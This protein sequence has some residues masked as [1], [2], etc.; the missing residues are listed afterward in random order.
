MSQESELPREFTA[1][2]SEI[3]P[4]RAGAILSSFEIAKRPCVWLNSM[5]GDPEDTRGEIAALGVELERL[6][7]VRDACL[8]RARDRDALV[9]A[10]AFARG[11]F[12]LQN[13]SSL[14][15]PQ[16]LAAREHEEILDLAAAPGGKT[17]Q[18]AAMMANRGRIAAVESVKGRYYRMKANLERSGVANAALYLMDG[19]AVGRKTP[20]RFDAVLLDAPCSSEGR[21]RARE[22]SSFRHWSLRKVREC[23]R[24]QRGLIKSALRALKPGGRLLYCTCSFAPEENELVIQHALDAMGPTL[25]VVNVDVPILNISPGLTRWRDKALDPRLDRAV[26]II[27]NAAFDAFFVCLLE[28]G[29]DPGV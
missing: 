14:L 21:F 22:P 10:P 27:P 4:A 7:W 12:Y 11:A 17:I 29:S 28:K 26:R 6:P 15:A 23:S 20:E 8:A 13:P 3:D 24:K 9:H 18:L 5:V 16:L 1:R 2:L 19:R 25:Q